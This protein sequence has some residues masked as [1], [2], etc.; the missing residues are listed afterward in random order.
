MKRQDWLCLVAVHSDSWLMAI[1]FYNGARLDAEG[2]WV[3]ACAG[4]A[5]G[6][7]TA[8]AAGG[9]VGLVWGCAGTPAPL[10]GAPLEHKLWSSPS[11]WQAALLEL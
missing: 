3:P 6:G 5:L 8:A 9:A 10:L 4:R 1:A 7:G 2:R 11:G